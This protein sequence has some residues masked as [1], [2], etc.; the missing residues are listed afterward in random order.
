MYIYDG[1]SEESTLL[2]AY[3]LGAEMPPSVTTTG[4]A[5]YIKYTTNEYGRSPGWEIFY[6]SVYVNN[7]QNINNSI[8]VYPNPAKNQLNILGL[9][10]NSNISICDLSGKVMKEISANNRGSID[11]TDLENGVYFVR[12][13]SAKATEVLKFIKH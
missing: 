6:S 7:K 13:K 10:D 3:T 1:D 11:I 9:V 4:N 8:S 5:A 2:G 12:I